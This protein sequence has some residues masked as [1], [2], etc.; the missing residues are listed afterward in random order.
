MSR[1]EFNGLLGVAKQQVPFGIYAVE[2]HGYAELLNI[3]CDSITQ[4]KNSTRVYVQ[5]GF[6]DT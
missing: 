2:R 1:Q 5:N 6:Y 3:K 4:L